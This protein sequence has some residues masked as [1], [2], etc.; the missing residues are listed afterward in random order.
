M[1]LTI[2]TDGGSRGNPGPSG[3]GVV[4]VDE[5]GKVHYAAGEYLGVKTNNEA[6]YLALLHSLR[7]LKAAN[8]TSITAVQY[9]LDSK[10]V[11]EQ[12]QKHWKIKEARLLSLAQE[13]WTLLSELKYPVKFQHV[14]RAANTEADRLANQAMDQGTMSAS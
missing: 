4:I 2:Q 3:I 1:L 11:V 13:C 12:I 14:L 8:P 10:L 7:W 9:K 5:T 6:E